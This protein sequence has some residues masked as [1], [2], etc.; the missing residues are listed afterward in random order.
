MHNRLDDKVPDFLLNPGYR[1]YRHLI[2]QAFVFLISLNVFWDAEEKMI[3]ERVGVW[4][5]Y[6]LLLDAIVYL[7]N[8]VL[9]PRLLLRN[10]I[11]FYTLSVA[12][13]IPVA[14]FCI[15]LLQGISSPVGEDS[16]VPEMLMGIISSV[17]TL[18]LFIAGVSTL[19]FFKYRIK[20]SLRIDELKSATMQSELKYLKSQ[21]NPHFLFNMLNNANIMVHEDAVIASHILA[22]LNDLLRY[23]INDSAGDSVRLDADIS[24]LNDFLELEKSV[25]MRLTARFQKRVILPLFRY[26]R[27][28]LSLS[29]KMRSN[30]VR[31]ANAVRMYILSSM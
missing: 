20:Q 16:N 6:F 17:L 9:F 15:G 11:L 18:G 12:V 8:Y 2:L 21:I 31:T 29:W 23:Q 30:T 22:K 14:V 24:F 3:G 13:L 5:A 28:C 25:A 1:L 19:L 7:N 26:R 27:C 4:C 10:K